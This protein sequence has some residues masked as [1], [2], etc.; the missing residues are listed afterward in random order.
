MNYTE[1]EA[2]VR[3]ATNDEAWGPTG[4]LMQELAHATF[5]YEQFPEVMSMLWKRMLQDNKQHW[6][7][8]YKALLVLAYLI[9]NGSERVVTSAR[10]HIYDL[11]SLEN[12]T[13]HDEYGKDQ[14]VNVRHKVRELIE[15]VGDDDKLREERKKAKKN[16][17]KYIGM[18]SDSVGLR[19]ESGGVS[20]GGGAGGE[21]GDGRYRDRSYDDEYDGEKEDSDNDSGN[22]NTGGG[23][24][25]YR[26][27]EA[28]RDSL[29]PVTANSPP[30]VRGVMAVRSPARPQPQS[31][32]V[33]KIDLGA[34]AVFARD[35]SSASS[36]TDTTTVTGQHDF[37]NNNVDLLANVDNGTCVLSTVVCMYVYVR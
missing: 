35:A 21:W 34:A 28:P 29:S 9:R 20:G 12:Y 36:V 31:R 8:T 4:Q 23:A 22:H 19:W 24:R 15:F 7:R 30:V 2:K 17:D 26:D 27:T 32:A 6:R 13:F 25:R 33:K 16:K 1:T 5:T 11:R 14:G 3:E 37:T 10:E 18:S